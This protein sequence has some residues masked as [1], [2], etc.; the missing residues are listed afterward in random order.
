MENLLQ[1]WLPEQQRVQVQQQ[2]PLP[3]LCQP[4]LR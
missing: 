4:R 2:V 1:S 3:G